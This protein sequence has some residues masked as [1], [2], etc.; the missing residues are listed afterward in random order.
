MF[1]IYA[2]QSALA[3]VA[4]A[5]VGGSLAF[6]PSLV[7]AVLA[8]VLGIVLGNWTRTVIIKGLRA[9]QF[10]KLVSDTRLKEFLQKAEV[11][12]RAEV[13]VGTLAKWLVV[14]I[15]FI[16]ATNILGL[17]TV[18]ALLA[19]ILGY[20]PSVISAVI[21]LA[22]GVFLAGIVERVVKGALA[23]VDLH[24]SRLMG[25]VASYTVVTIAT[26]AAFSELRIASSFIN[27]LFIGFVAMLALGLGLAIGLGGKDL[28]SQI[29][30]DWYKDLAK[31]LKKKK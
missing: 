28:V 26:L 5:T 22:I 9:L 23:S 11:T 27:I 21:V 4:G 18:S 14:M 10:D 2:W 20:I 29:L 15:F 31:D 16:A 8:V 24:T 25:K 7:G 6:F 30:S 19:G 12:S 13:V 1:D 3:G 17:T